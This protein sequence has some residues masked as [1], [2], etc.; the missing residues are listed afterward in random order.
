MAVGNEQLAKLSIASLEDPALQVDAMFNPKELGVDRRVPWTPHADPL[1]DM[2]KLEFTNGENG[3]MSLELLF[4]TTEKAQDVYAL[5]VSRLEQMTRIP[6]RVTRDEDKH[7]P[8]VKV[9]W[10]TRFPRFYGV[11]ESFGCKYTMFLPDGTP[12]RASCTI[13]VKE[14]DY[15][16][17]K[18]E[19]KKQGRK[20]GYTGWYR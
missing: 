20:Y 9:V 5:Y 18:E 10:G 4:D 13:K 17:L 2:K 8:H 7:P 11:I 1:S 3:T 14:I 16:Q 12:T 6:A 19:W 15:A